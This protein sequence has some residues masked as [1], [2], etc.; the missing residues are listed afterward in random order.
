MILQVAKGLGMYPKLSLLHNILLDKGFCQHTPLTQTLN[1]DR[2]CNLLGI[3]TVSLQIINKI[4]IIHTC[5]L[6]PQFWYI[7]LIR[8]VA[9]LLQ[10]HFQSQILS[11]RIYVLLFPVQN[12]KYNTTCCRTI[13]TILL[14]FIQ[15]KLHASLV[16]MQS[17]VRSERN[18]SNPNSV[19]KIITLSKAFSY[20]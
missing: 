19:S 14:F 20:C 17:N 9:L 8:H 3:S 1:G 5:K 2:S 12:E 7:C 18:I 10:V 16:I 11:S 6:F 4:T 13:Q 15:P